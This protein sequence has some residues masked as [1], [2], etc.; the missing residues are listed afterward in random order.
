M[1]FLGGAVCLPAD[2]LSLSPVW[3]I[4]PLLGAA[5][6][7]PP[8]LSTAAAAAAS[9]ALVDRRRT[10]LTA[11][12]TQPRS[13]FEVAQLALTRGWIEQQL[14][15][16]VDDDGWERHPSDGRSHQQLSQPRDAKAE[17]P[18]PSSPQ[19]P[20]RSM[21]VAR[22][23]SAVYGAMHSQLRAHDGAQRGIAAAHFHRFSQCIRTHQPRAHLQQ[24]MQASVPSDDSRERLIDASPSSVI[25]SL[26]LVP[27]A[28]GGLQAFEGGGA[29][30]V[31]EVDSDGGAEN[32]WSFSALFPTC[33]CP[34]PSALAAKDDG[35][36]CC[37]ALCCSSPHCLTFHR[38][39]FCSAGSLLQLDA[40]AA[41]AVDEASEGTE[42]GGGA[43][44][45]CGSGRANPNQ[46]ARIDLTQDTDAL[47]S[48]L[49]S[50]SSAPSPA[51]AAADA[52]SISS[53]STSHSSTAVDHSACDRLLTDMQQ[54]W[55]R[56]EEQTQ[57][58]EEMEGPV[59]LDEGWKGPPSSTFELTAR[60][61]E[62]REQ[63]QPSHALMAELDAIDEDDERD[64]HDDD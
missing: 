20:L 27:R 48:L 47:L 35:D 2:I 28:G 52:P 46:P 7:C 12:C 36:G 34:V 22:V 40:P 19:Q 55:R 62:S 26:F 8:R 58:G 60:Q 10:E 53:T 31:G 4:A 45:R 32:G 44:G 24:P 38:V 50:H 17:W 43:E 16:D 23:A 39:V 42:K 6:R 14:T 18:R 25:L 3:T 5:I 11:F 33:S 1:T 64:A 51:P 59:D 9:A 54:Q 61:G 37:P 15:D 63:E 29:G 57:R 56:W 30:P 21:E 49:H 41:A 13:A